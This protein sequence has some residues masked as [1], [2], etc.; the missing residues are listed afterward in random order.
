M[1]IS[2]FALIVKAAKTCNG[3]STQISTLDK[4]F[5]LCKGFSLSIYAVKSFVDRNW[6]MKNYVCDKEYVTNASVSD[7]TVSQHD[8]LIYWVYQVGNR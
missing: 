2:G 8:I 6:L 7:C 1:V 3:L 4:T 5:T